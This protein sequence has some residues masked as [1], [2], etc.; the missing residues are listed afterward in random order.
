[1]KHPVKNLFQ[2]YIYTPFSKYFQTSAR[3]DK[4]QYTDPTSATYLTS[5]I[6]PVIVCVFIA[7][8]EA[9]VFLSVYEM[10]V[11]TIMLSFCEDCGNSGG[12]KYAPPLLMGALG[13]TSDPK[14]KPN[15]ND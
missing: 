3:Y 14:I 1:M 6:L 7:Y 13:K 2:I 5:P 12:P 10:A 9:D 15:D 8:C 11:D 4:E